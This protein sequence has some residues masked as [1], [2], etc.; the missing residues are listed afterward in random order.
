MK[1]KGIETIAI[2]G[3]KVVKIQYS[4][5]PIVKTNFNIQMNLDF[6]NRMLKFHSQDTIGT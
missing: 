1:F 3:K 4:K 5:S 6:K 2:Y